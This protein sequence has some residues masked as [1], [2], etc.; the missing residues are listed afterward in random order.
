M[1]FHLPPWIARACS[2]LLAAACGLGSASAQGTKSPYQISE[3]DNGLDVVVIENRTVP[4]ATIAIAV[5][6]GAFT[7]SDEYAGLS[8]LY[9]HMFF[10]A[11]AAIPS[12]EGFMQKV[13]ELGIV[14]NGYTSQEVVTYY[15]TLP[16]KNL[17]PGMKF[18]ADAIKSPLF[19][20]EELVRER[21]VVL[22]EFDRNE[23]QPTF[24]LSRAIDSAM[25]MPY[26]SRK[27][28]LGQRQVIKTA[29]VEKMRMIKDLFYHPNNS[30]LIVSGDVRQEQ[31]AALAKKYLGDWK[32][33]KN[34]F[35]A[36][37]PP[38]FPPLA[39]KLV[40][41]EA[42]I[43][44]VDLRLHF[45]GPSLAKDD[46]D[47]YIGDLLSTL[48]N[49]PT[50]RLFHNLMD[51]GLVTGIN[52]GYGGASNTGVVSFYLRSP[53]EKAERAL[54]V[55]R[56]EIRA[57]AQPGYFTSE[58]IDI[59]KGIVADQYLFEQDNFHSFT[60]GSTARWWSMTSLDYYLNFDT[61]VQKVTAEEMRRFVERYMIGKPFILGVGAE[62]A[63]L[64]QLNITEEAL[65]W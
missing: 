61:N 44:D 50:S 24:V 36:Y 58:E 13:R 19:K 31:V 18:M 9:E 63:T 29:T 25:W 4:L 21:E 49:Q 1:N 15:F 47:T 55:L 59:A 48:I 8:H 54:E 43:P 52:A 28:P 62:R 42:K 3:L 46:P 37:A 10:K 20:D 53:K 34:P 57:M 51:S 26:V 5:R 7:E 64:D 32:P 38:P 30:A 35:P 65:R 60:I 27:Q 6:N 23:A 2:L 14:Y 41:R 40:V 12:Q 56:K 39:S 17:D 16:S 22:G 33:G 45:R 11:N